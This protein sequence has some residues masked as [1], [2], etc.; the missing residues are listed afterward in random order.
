[1]LNVILQSPILTERE[2]AKPKLAWKFEIKIKEIQHKRQTQS[3]PVPPFAGA[4][5]ENTINMKLKIAL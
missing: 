3:T 5:E 1:M 2:R 4:G